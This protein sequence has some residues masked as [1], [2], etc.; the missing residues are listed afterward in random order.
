MVGDGAAVPFLEV[1]K[2]FDSLVGMF[3]GDF[4]LA[5][6]GT[7]FAVA[8]MAVRNVCQRHGL[9]PPETATDEVARA[10][11]SARP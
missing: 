11:L 5:D 10:V 9:G 7:R 2:E 6:T 8:R 3:A 1:L 4:N